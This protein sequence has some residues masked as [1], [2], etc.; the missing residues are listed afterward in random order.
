[1]ER[2][3]QG[4]VRVTSAT[5]SREAER[6]FVA[7]AV[8]AERA[9]PAHLAVGDTIGVDLG[10]LALATL[11]DGTVI[12][13]PKSLRRG[14]RKL[15]R[16]SRAHSRK[17][18]GSRNRARAARRLARHHAKVATIR[19]DHLHKLTTTLAKTH[20]QI[21]VEDL[22]VKGMLGNRQLA[23]ALS[24]SGF[25]EFRRQLSYK[26][27]WYGS[28]L[29]VADRWFPSSKRCCG[30]GTVKAELSLSERIYH[31]QSCGL[32]LDRDLN[33]AI[34]LAGWAHPVVTASAAETLTACG[35]DR[36]TGPRPAGGREAGT[37]IAPEPTGSIGGPH[38]R[39]PLV[40]V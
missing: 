9:I 18:P 3:A 27:Q 13:G 35:A 10:V 20:G 36:K 25:S 24:D 32:V 12:S 14:L 28:E 34:N 2:I 30:C 7:L 33:A 22:N 1:M 16:L 31:C 37:G 21:V 29:V 26:C 11:S 5:V 40:A 19:R 15:R 17:R 8:E 6:W 39:A 38:T 23:R 4:S